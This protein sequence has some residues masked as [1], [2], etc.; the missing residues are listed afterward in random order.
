MQKNDLLT[1][2]EFSKLACTTKRTIQFYDEL[3]ILKPFQVDIKGY[4]YYKQRQILDFQVITLLR[5][6]GLSLDDIKNYLDKDQ[7]L[8]NIFKKKKTL[9]TEELM[10]MKYTL[11][12]LNTYFKN[13]DKNGTMIK[14]ECKK[15]KP[16]K[17]Y[18]IEK[19]GS[20]SQIGNYC[21][22]ILKMLRRKS[23]SVTPLAIFEEKGYRPEKS[24]VKIGVIWEKNIVVKD[25]YKGI[26]KEMRVPGFKALTYIHN[27]S[28]RTLSLFWK[29]LEKYARKRKIK[30]NSDIPNM[31]GLEIYWKISDKD[32][33]QFFEIY[34]PIA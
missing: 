28:G 25:R 15:V 26:I 23:K 22:E 19:V 32:Y 24:K 30:L 9:I 6:L 4:R 14:A 29:E 17:I 34:M 12:S 21:K 2:G 5:N 16:F 11:K 20:Y 31:K 27:G 33:E 8:K 7:S 18:Y 3:G 1:T 10:Y 13:L